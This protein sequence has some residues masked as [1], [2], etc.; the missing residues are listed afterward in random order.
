M[1]ERYG[2]F[3]TERAARMAGALAHEL[4]NPLQG[5]VSSLAAAEA[6]ASSDSGAKLKIELIAGGVRRLSKT[7]E[8]F[9]AV[10]ENLPRVPDRITR[11]CLTQAFIDA[12]E[13]VFPLSF[14]ESRER[15]GSN[16]CAMLCYAAETVR[17]LRDSIAQVQGELHTL[18]MHVVQCNQNY[19]YE[20]ILAGRSE[21]QMWHAVEDAR[22][23]GGLV[24]LLDEIVR[25][26]GGKVSVS[27]AANR[28]SGIALKLCC[29]DQLA[30]EEHS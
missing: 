4:N 9:S 26:A 3:E 21:Q 19:V 28:V 10:Y 16:G 29:A 20:F 14:A 8:S 7:V 25:M 17:L 11:A 27:F 18:T 12:L 2:M 5:L 6:D 22:G 15:Q 30:G 1:L 13:P 23:V 24:V